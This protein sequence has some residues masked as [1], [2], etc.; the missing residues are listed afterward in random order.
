MTSWISHLN[1]LREQINMHWGSAQ[2][3]QHMQE[4]F[5]RKSLQAAPLLDRL[6]RFMADY[7]NLLQNEIKEYA[8]E[9]TE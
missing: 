1:N 8:I 5:V 2:E 4:E 6:G 7:A 3:S 9:N